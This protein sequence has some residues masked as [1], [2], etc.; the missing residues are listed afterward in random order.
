[1]SQS[2]N[3]ELV[4]PQE[5]VTPQTDDRY[6]RR[7]GLIVLGLL[8]GIFGVWGSLAPLKST[9][10]ASGKVS[11]ASS[12]RMVQHLEGGI[13][14]AILTKDGETV[15]SG[16]SLMEL[17]TT[18]TNAQ[19]QITL[20]QYYENLGLEGRLI[21]ERDGKSTITFNPELKMQKMIMDAQ[22]NE[23]HVRAQQL[24]GQKQILSERIEQS[25]N[26]IEGLE[27]TVAAKMSLSRSYADEIK[28][29]EV[30]YAQQL[31]DKNRMRDVKRDKMRV[32]SEIANA[33]SDIARVKGQIGEIEAQIIGQKQT[34]MKEVVAQLSEVQAHLSDLR[35]RLAAM[36]DT[37]ERGTIKA[38]VGGIV[39]NLQIHTIGGI[40]APG[41]PILEIV[42]E[43]EPLIID[44]KVMASDITNV[45]VGLK[46]EIR[47]PG[48]AHVK[49]LNI[50]EGEVMQ[51]APDSTV[52][53][54]AKVP[55]YALKIQVTPEGQKELLRN[56]LTIQPGIPAE[57]MIVTAS[58]T[59]M[60]Y[61]IHPFKTM[62]AK[63]FNEQ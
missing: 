19:L 10:S 45:H 4:V 12:N 42:P 14:K 40:I 54:Q 52:D 5:V 27:A 30:L 7:L 8:V 61:M 32:D 50:V 23:F 26:Q 33:K 21:A 63:A 38:P 24:T 28:E 16:Q 62:F 13:V 20:G 34:F 41:R 18:Q 3:T 47:F 58:R 51:I 55:T 35:P 17:D 60:D 36:N 6:Y 31:I 43:G 2:D 9:I 37:V 25:R 49:T 15:Q 22:R 11:V 56:H 44:A 48:F 39:A 46:A 53:E 57:A 29:L 1:M 59:F